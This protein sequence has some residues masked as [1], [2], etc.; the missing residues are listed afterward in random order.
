MPSIV[1][2]IDGEVRVNMFPRQHEFISSE[3]D[4]AFYGGALG[5]GKSVAL[6]LFSVLR[7]V[8]YPMSHGIILRRTF[9]Q[10]EN[11]IILESH[12][13]FPQFGAVYNE[14]KKRWTFPNGSIQNF[15]YCERDGDVFNYHSDNYDDMCFDESSHFNQF[16]FTYLTSRCR[17]SIPGCKALIRSA[18]NPGNVGHDFF[19]KRYIIPSKTQKIWTD[20][21]TKKTMTF[22]SA[23]V[24]D[25][26]ALME[27]DPGYLERLRELPEKKYLALAEGRWDVFEGVYFSEWNERLHVLPYNRVPDTFT[28][29]FISLDWGFAD[30]ACALWW[31]VT[32]MGRAFIYR[33]LYVTKLHPTELAEKI[34]SL[35]P[36]YEKYD[37]LCA[38]P[39]IWGKSADLKEG[40]ETIHQMMSR[41]FGPRIEMIKAMNARVPG[42]L[43]MREWMSMA[44][45]G[46]PW[47]QISPSCENLVRTIPGA[48]HAEPPAN[49]EDINEDCEDHALESAR[50]GAVSLMNIQRGEAHPGMSGYERIFGKNGDQSSNVSFIPPMGR[51]GYGR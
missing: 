37:Y 29:K 47:L 39:E 36:E 2:K 35:S 6:L 38:S 15:G 21:A 31:E 42:W 17:T 1:E 9:R 48:I 41:A 26:P 23:K 10:L 25:N 33:E 22:I 24:T 4:D 7:R 46:R 34:I 40:G 8:R 16:Q 32:P 43:K 14:Q 51:S 19:N 11:S 45:D 18:S 5:G 27:N 44:P 30:P 13:I 20:P 28:K 12:K 49:P 3:V 50:Y